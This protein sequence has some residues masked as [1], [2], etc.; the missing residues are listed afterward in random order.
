M[1][2]N[3]IMR[4]IFPIKESINW[5]EVK[6]LPITP[7]LECEKIDYNTTLNLEQTAIDNTTLLQIQ[8]KEVFNTVRITKPSLFVWL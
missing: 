6:K 1:V 5:T 7:S 3:N 2:I 8:F 4:A